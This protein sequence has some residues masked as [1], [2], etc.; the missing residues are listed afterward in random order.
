MRT[1]RWPN[2]LLVLTHGT[3]QILY[4]RQ[5]N[6]CL[7]AEKHMKRFCSSV[8]WQVY[9]YILSWFLLSLSWL[10][11][12]NGMTWHGF[13]KVKV[14]AD[15]PYIYNTD[16]AFS[17]FFFHLYCKTQSVKFRVCLKIYQVQWFYILKGDIGRSNRLQNQRDTKT[18][19]N[20]RQISESVR[21]HK[22]YSLF[23]RHPFARLYFSLS[24]FVSQRKHMRWWAARWEGSHESRLAAV[25]M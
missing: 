5:K 25:K 7:L 15:V 13:L 6:C 3:N 12:T 2:A 4:L 20:H 17:S 8:W 16:T 19:W 10:L 22:C 23:S 24:S 1:N 18:W 14:N 11:V 9:F 21:L